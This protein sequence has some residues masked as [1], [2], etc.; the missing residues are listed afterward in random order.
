MDF[1]NTKVFGRTISIPDDVKVIWVADL[2]VEDYVGGAELTSEALIETTPVPL[3]KL[4][5]QDVTMDLLKQYQDRYWVFS[6]FSQM[7]LDIIPAIVVNMKYSIIEYDYKFCRYRNPEKH[8]QETGQECDCNDLNHGK[9][10]AGFY[11]GAKS[12]WFMSEKQMQIYEERFPKMDMSRMAVL[13][14]VFND[15]TFAYIKALREQHKD[16]ER[17][18]W[19]VLGSNS[20]V[21]GAEQSEQ[22]CKDNN[23]D[24]EVVWGLPYHELLEK[25]AKAE[26]FAYHPKGE[27]T[28]PRMVIEAKL[29]GCKLELNDFVQHKDEDWFNVGDSDE[30]ILSVEQYLYGARKWFWT[31]IVNDMEYIPSISGYTTTKDCIK[32]RYPYKACIESMLS[33]CDEVVVL[34]GGSKDGTREHLLEWSKEEPKLK[35]VIHDFDWDHPHFAVFD[36]K[37]KDMAREA[38]TMDFC[39]QMDSDEIVHEDDAEKIKHIVRDFPP[40]FDLLALPVIEYWGG[41]DKVRT[42]I[43]PWK[44]R[45]SRNKSDIGHGIPKHLRETGEHGLYAKVGTDGCDPIYRSS[46]QLI[47]FANFYTADVE[48]IRRRVQEDQGALE[49]YEGWYNDIANNLPC[50][51]HYSWWDIERKIYTYKNYWGKHWRALYNMDIEDTAENNVMF[52]VPWSEVTDEMIKQ[53]AKELKE[54]TG[55]HIFHAPWDGTETKHVTIQKSMPKYIEEWINE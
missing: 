27:D 32:Q 17:K 49:M 6:N 5:S 52:D 9:L 35:V 42:D 40:N 30:D 25:L 41:P 39:W 3:Y 54:K 34:D 11:Q 14:S 8:K 13:S 12:V 7:N 18:G 28:C 23:L 33:F 31:A 24:Y 10:I 43:Q 47:P 36:G 55:G 37:A 26:G 48:M 16:T 29:L 46:G 21:K 1:T 2:F 20:W 4:H 53:K 45:L 51:Y 44:W 19:I 15:K 50:I 22:Y 38:C